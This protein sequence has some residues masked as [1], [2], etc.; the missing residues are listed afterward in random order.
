MVADNVGKSGLLHV[1][2]DLHKMVEPFVAFGMFRR[3]PSRKHQDELVGYT[4][5]INHFVL[6]IS[7]MDV[8]AFECHLRHCGIEVL[9]FEFPYLAAVHCIGPVG[10]EPL[11]IKLVCTLA[12]FLVRIERDADIAMFD[13]R[14]LLQISHRRYYLGHTGLVI[15]SQQCSPVGHYQVLTPVMQQFGKLRRTEHDILLLVKCY[16]ASV[17]AFH[18]PGIYVMPR[19]VGRRIQMGY[20]PYGGNFTLNVRRQCCHK[21]TV[22]IERNIRKTQFTQLLF[23]RLRESELPGGGRGQVGKFVALRVELHISEKSVS[24]IHG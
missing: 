24:N 5:R 11:D 13:F 14:M 23:K 12:D 1:T 15:G 22:V 8:A 7:G 2:L 17:V 18:Y 3:F 16:I 6:G 4:D 9:I 19:H 21:I 10:A 20:E